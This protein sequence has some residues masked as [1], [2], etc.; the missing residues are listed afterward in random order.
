MEN[1]K[2]MLILLYQL[3]QKDLK[4]FEFKENLKV[5]PETIIKKEKQIT[6]IKANFENKKAEYV[7]LNSLKKEKEALLAAKEAA[8]AKHTADLNTIKVND[9]YKN[10]LLEIEK[11]KADKSV[12]ED[13]ILQLMED[14]DKEV[15]NLKKYE[16]DSK[17]KEAELNKEIADTRKIV[18]KSKEN[19]I[20]MQE[21]R[22]TFAKNIDKN[23]LSQ[24][25]RI[26]EGRNGQGLATIEGDSCSGCNMVL[27]PQLIVQAT[28][29]KE[30]VYCDN[31][32][33]ILFN[34][35][36]IQE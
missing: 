21:E 2:D 6:E 5:L 34:K 35:K 16:E 9:V 24:Y 15:V 17:A 10:C 22:D 30:L 29:C 27:R 36:D 31:C 28:K 13:E 18:E 8:I 12:V 23:V 1:L 4:I 33:R 19:I 11:A 26:R 20:L 32:S 14:I 3:Q 7:R 25:E